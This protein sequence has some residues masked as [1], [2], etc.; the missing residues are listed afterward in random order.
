MLQGPPI[1]SAAWRHCQAVA[2]WGAR[3]GCYDSAPAAG[4]GLL[5]VDD[6]EPNLGLKLEAGYLS[7]FD[8]IE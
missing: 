6:D 8:F 7:P 2:A 3:Q 5:P 1:R 4:L